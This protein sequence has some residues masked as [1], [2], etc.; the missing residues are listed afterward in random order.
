[1]ARSWYAYLGF[2]DPT[3]F[4]SYARLTVKHQCL[5]GDRICAIYVAADT[6]RLESPLSDNLQEYIRNALLT[7]QIQPERP[8]GTKK[9]V[10]LKPS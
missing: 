3:S 1:M 6:F 5:C 4:T 10:Y 2:G 9:Y 8:T 7:G